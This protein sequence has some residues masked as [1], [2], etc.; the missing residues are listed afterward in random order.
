MW[1]TNAGQFV[2]A[3]K[4]LCGAFLVSLRFRSVP[5]GVSLSF[6]LRF[7][8]PCAVGDHSFE[9]LATFDDASWPCLACHCEEFECGG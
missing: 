7:A 5:F 4:T 2:V 1:V 6:A 9:H 8:V 3:R